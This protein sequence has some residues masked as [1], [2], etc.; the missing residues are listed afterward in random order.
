MSRR[1]HFVC[2]SGRR[3]CEYYASGHVPP[4]KLTRD[5]NA[6]TCRRCLQWI[7]SARMVDGGTADRGWREG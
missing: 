5:P 1:V 7:E 2:E 6:V 3:P 4:S